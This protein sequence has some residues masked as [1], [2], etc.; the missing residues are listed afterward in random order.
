MNWVFLKLN[1]CLKGLLNWGAK[2]KKNIQ[3]KSSCSSGSEKQ[4]SAFSYKS[5]VT[6]KASLFER[7]HGDYSPDFINY[8][9]KIRTIASDNHGL[10][11]IH[12]TLLL[13]AS[14]SS[15]V[16][17]KSFSFWKYR[18]VLI[19]SFTDWASWLLPGNLKGKP[20]PELCRSTSEQKAEKP[21][22]VKKVYSKKLRDCCNSLQRLEKCNFNFFFNRFYFSLASVFQRT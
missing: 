22:K 11:N 8:L 17:I 16:L 3:G 19:Y 12:K 9:C 14:Y 15:C 20:I 6:E 10:Q 1:T 4:K 2:K 21:A 5:K 7:H 18:L 13:P